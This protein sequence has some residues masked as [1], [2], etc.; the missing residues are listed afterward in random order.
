M[1]KKRIYEYARE[2]EKSSKEV[3]DTLIEMGEDITNHMS[4]ISEDVQ[5]KLMEKFD[6]ENTEPTETPEDYE[7]IEA[8]PKEEPEKVDDKNKIETRERT[9]D[10]EKIEPTHKEETKKEDDKNKNIYEKTITVEQLAGKLNKDISEIIKKLMFSGVMATK[11][12]DL[13]DDAIEL[14]AEDY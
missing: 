5:F 12:E 11:N 7:T 6:E 13:S 1:N 8:Q 3:V 2:I 10:S 14:I 4:T 9:K